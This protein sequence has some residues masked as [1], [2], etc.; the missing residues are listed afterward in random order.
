MDPRF[1]GSTVALM[2]GLLFLMTAPSR[3]RDRFPQT[4]NGVGTIVG[5]LAYRSLKRRRLGLCDNSIGRRVVEGAALVSIVA[6]VLLQSNVLVHM[7]SEPVPNH[8]IPAWE[9]LLA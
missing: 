6:L 5:A 3:G 1:V 2:L 8:L 4:L 9:Q 7:S